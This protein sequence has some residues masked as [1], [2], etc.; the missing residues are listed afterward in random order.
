M[1]NP[2]IAE[3]GKNTRWQPGQSGNP[4]GVEPGTVHLSTLIKEMMSDESFTALLPDPKQ[5]YLEF[6]GAPAKAIVKVVIIRAA[7]GEKESREWLAKYGYG[8]KLEV[9]NSGEQTITVITRNAG[10][11]QQALE[12]EIVTDDGIEVIQPSE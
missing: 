3:A 6:K 11:E 4:K 9:E 7:Q 1:P 2:N 10:K 12:A 8:S 5:G